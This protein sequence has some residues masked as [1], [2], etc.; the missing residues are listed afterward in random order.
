MWLLG[1]NEKSL[2]NVDRFNGIHIYKTKIDNRY[3]ITGID[4]GTGAEIDLAEYE[5][6]ERAKDVLVDL[7][8]NIDKL[9]YVMPV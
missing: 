9:R 1:Q 2:F 4:K 7:L 3:C 6:E 5:T 8:S